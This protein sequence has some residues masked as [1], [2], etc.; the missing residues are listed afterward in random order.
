MPA[1]DF[2]GIDIFEDFQ[3]TTKLMSVSILQLHFEYVMVTNY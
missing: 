3:M 2:D 1:K